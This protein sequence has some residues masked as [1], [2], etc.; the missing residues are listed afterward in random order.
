MRLVIKDLIISVL[1]WTIAIAFSVTIRFLGIDWVLQ[2]PYYQSIGLYYLVSLPGGILGGL[3]FG[4][5]EIFDDRLRLK[6]ARS[7]GYVVLT[8]TIIYIIAF[9]SLPHG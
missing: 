3:L 1:Y 9:H 5:I 8:K 7:F 2:S 6:T 4:L